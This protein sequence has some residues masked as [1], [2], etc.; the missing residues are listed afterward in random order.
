MSPLKMMAE[1]GKEQKYKEVALEFNETRS[2][3]WSQDDIWETREVPASSVRRL[4]EAGSWHH[5]ISGDT[6]NMFFF[7][8][9]NLY[10]YI[11]IDI[12]HE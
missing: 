1:V 3:V 6:E 5:D 9:D 10:V 7:F 11:Y 4:P 2:P 12:K 8:Y